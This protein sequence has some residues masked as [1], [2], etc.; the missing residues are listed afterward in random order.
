MNHIRRIPAALATALPTVARFVRQCAAQVLGVP[1]YGPAGRC[2]EPAAARPA[3][4]PAG[5]LLTGLGRQRD[6]RP[7]GRGG[8]P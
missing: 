7:E 3:K 8:R 6:Q 5:L 1:T 2:L 4:T